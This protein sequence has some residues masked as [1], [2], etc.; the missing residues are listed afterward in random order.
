[1]PIRPV[2]YYLMLLGMDRQLQLATLGFGVYRREDPVMNT[3]D[4]LL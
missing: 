3:P 1:M 2:H 4:Q